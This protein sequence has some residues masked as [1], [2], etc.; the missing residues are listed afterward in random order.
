VVVLLL[1]WL[2]AASVA[3]ALPVGY[4]VVLAAYFALMLAY[5][6]RVHD[7]RVVD[8]LLLGCGY[9][10][11]IVAGSAAVGVA[12]SAWLLACSALLF[13]S[14]ALLKRSS[15]LALI[16]V[17]VGAGEHTHGYRVGDAPMVAAV[18][19]AAGAA[20]MAVLAIYPLSEATAHAGRWLIWAGCLLT[21]YW[22]RRMWRIAGEG[23]IRDDPVMFSLR[24]PPS[25][26]V[27]A[28]VL[29]LFV[30]AA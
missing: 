5:V 7:M 17:Q 27:G 25:L 21:L 14:L 24:D 1:L 13:F 26:A 20:A 6:L 22:M 2:G 11:R 30:A 8:A 12:V 10:L 4:R 23:R 19:R 15:E 18:G 28:I 3:L 29:A 9:T 16:G